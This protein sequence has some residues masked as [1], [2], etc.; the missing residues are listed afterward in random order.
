MAAATQHKRPISRED[1]I[2]HT[3]NYIVFG[4]VALICFYPF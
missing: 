4:F 1:K 3:V 2:F